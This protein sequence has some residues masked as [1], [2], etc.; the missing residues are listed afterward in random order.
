MIDDRQEIEALWNPFLVAWFSKGL[1]V[2]CEP[3]LCDKNEFGRGSH[4]RL[5]R[6]DCEKENTNGYAN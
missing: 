4:D 6:T 3:L 1:P 2:V 5:L